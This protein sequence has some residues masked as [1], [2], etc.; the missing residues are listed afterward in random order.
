MDSRILV[1]LAVLVYCAL[2]I[3]YQILFTLFLQINSDTSVIYLIIEKRGLVELQ[4]YTFGCGFNFLQTAWHQPR[5]PGGL[6][7]FYGTAAPLGYAA[8][9]GLNTPAVTRETYITEY[10][11]V[12]ESIHTLKTI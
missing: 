9:W 8:D 2:R 6:P 1:I 5:A 11:Q 12:S 3:V 10:A 4:N 7:P